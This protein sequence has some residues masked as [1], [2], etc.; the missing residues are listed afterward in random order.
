MEEI[1]LDFHPKEGVYARTV[2]K[3]HQ[4]EFAYYFNPDGDDNF[5][6][7]DYYTKIGIVG[8][9]RTDAK[10]GRL[11]DGNEIISFNA[12]KISNEEL[13]VTFWRQGDE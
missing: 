12:Q 6:V 1:V 9:V 5:M 3:R 13:L 7:I 11:N 8:F 10:R 2:G 4:I